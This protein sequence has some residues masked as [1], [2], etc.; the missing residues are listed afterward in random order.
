MADSDDAA[1][2][3]RQRDLVRRGYDAVSRA[4][5]SDDGAAATSSAEDASRYAQLTPTWDR[6]I[7][8]D[9]SGHTL[10]LAQAT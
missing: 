5:R 8:E 1:G 7:P 9:D 3:A 2:R 6:Y 10:I 4:Y